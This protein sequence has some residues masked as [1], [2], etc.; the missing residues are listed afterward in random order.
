VNA[1]VRI[2]GERLWSTIE[3]SA[4]IGVGRPGGLC[5][6][7][8]TD[9]DREMRDTFIGWARD[10]GYEARVDEIGSIF[11]RRRG[12]DDSLAPVVIG[13]HLDTQV[14]GGRYDGIVGVLAGLEVL[15]T[16]DDHG[17]E[18]RRSIEVVSWTNEEGARF[19]PP[20]MGS[21]VFA[22]VI[23]LEQALSVVDASGVTVGAELERIGYRGQEP[24]GGRPLDSYFELHIEQAPDLDASTVDVGVVTGSFAVHGVKVDVRGETAHTGPTPMDRRRNALVGAARLAVAVDDVGHRHQHTGGRATAA[25]ITSWPNATGII[26]EWAQLAFDVRH[27]DPDVAVAMLAEVEAE[28]PRIAER[29]NVDIEVIARWRFGDEEFDANCAE[30][31][32]DAGRALNIPVVDMMSIAGHDAYYISKV[33]P[34]ALIFTPCRDGVSHNEAEHADRHRTIPGVNVLLHAVI[35]R[36]DRPEDE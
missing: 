5:R 8:L 32:R 15:R 27:S 36:A 9:A 22:G 14:A 1:D 20:M 13:S 2:D 16:L 28:I 4:T 21:A 30:L 7:A 6:L 19:Q 25:S 34:T 29:N 24:V 11:V 10:A 26:A 3:T 23:P 17:I 12:A 35:A 33:A 31:V 18:T